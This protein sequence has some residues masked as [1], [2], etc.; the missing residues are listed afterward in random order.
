MC[1]MPNDLT[2]I[3]YTDNHLPSRFAW[4]VR[5]ELWTVA[6]QLRLPVVSVSQHPLSFGT[7]L[8]VGD[9]GRSY[10][11]IIRQILIGCIATDRP[12]VALCEHDVLYPAAHFAMRPDRGAVLFDQNRC[13]AL[14]DAG[15]YRP[16]VGGRSMQL[17]IGDRATLVEHFAAKLNRV[18]S[19]RQWHR[20]F[21]PGKE[22]ARLGLPQIPAMMQ[23]RTGPPI[24][25]I[26]N[27]GG[28]YGLRKPA[29]GSSV[30][31]LHPWGTIEDL[32]CRLHIGGGDGV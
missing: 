19:E 3:Y 6:E 26:I 25:N 31:A 15:V 14:I 23:D 4:S 13:H 30:N 22:E 11:S 10:R 18:T 1:E 32:K 16:N 2:I 20:V 12:Y 5:A 17:L 21:E 24:V 8:C 28:N 9:I 7:N 29:R 27:H